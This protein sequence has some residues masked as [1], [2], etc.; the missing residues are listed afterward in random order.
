ML[1]FLVLAGVLTTLGLSVPAEA[2]EPAPI[3]KKELLKKLQEKLGGK[4]DLEKLKQLRGGKK[5]VDTS[6]LKRLTWQ[7]GDVTRE[8]LLH[9]P[10]ASAKAPPLVFVFHGHGGKSG[11]VANSL[12]MHDLWPEAVVVYPQGLPTPTPIDT[13]GKMPG[14][15]KY[16]GDQNDRDLAFFDA[17]LKTIVADYKIDSKRVYSTGH[18]NGGYFTYVLVP[19]RGDQLAAIAPVAATHDARH[20]KDYKPKPIFHVAG[21]K[22][23]LVKYAA[24]EKTMEQMRKVNG[25]DPMGKPAGANCT[26]YT[27]ANGPP[28]ITFIH[29]GGHEV[30]AGAPERIVEFFKEHT[31]R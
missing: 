10:E 3:E 19:A 22:D 29:P 7:V 24:Q 15:Q 28:V 1:R 9:V 12:P 25:C 16:V 17:M 23:P 26:A 6:K 2:E 11:Q 27:S 21:E 30:P 13:Q 18:S 14:W 20:L 8:A 4:L 5:K 31:R